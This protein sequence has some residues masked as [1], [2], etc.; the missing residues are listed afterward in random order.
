MQTPSDIDRLARAA[1]EAITRAGRE[2]PAIGQLARPRRG[3]WRITLAVL[4]L[5]PAMVSQAHWAW[6]DEMTRY[7]LPGRARTAEQSE[8]QL[9]LGQARAAVEAART[10]SGGLPPALPSAALAALV[11]YERV[12]PSYRLSMAGREVLAS[13]D[14]DGVVDFQT[15][16]P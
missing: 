16:G 2:Q 6:L 1:D 9:V 11:R 10:P 4:I 12:G 8:L 3:A 5:L 14:G 13:M 7:L 15:L